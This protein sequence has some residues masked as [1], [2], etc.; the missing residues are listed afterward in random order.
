[1]LEVRTFKTYREMKNIHQKEMNEFPLGAAFSNEQFKEMMKKW[2]L[3]A[4]KDCDK[5]YSIGMGCFIRKSDAKEFDEILERFRLEEKLFRKEMRKATDQFYYELANHEYGL[6][7]DLEPTLD[8][9][10]ITIEEFENNEFL[11]TAMKKALMKYKK[12]MR[13]FDC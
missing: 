9:C 3:D 7:H 2:G 13:R 8:A 1:M 11:K 5:I 4:D 12:D 6:T 10:G